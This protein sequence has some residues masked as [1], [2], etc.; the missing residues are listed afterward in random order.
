MANSA[1]LVV[2]VKG[3]LIVLVGRGLSVSLVHL[4]TSGAATKELPPRCTLCM[5]WTWD[6]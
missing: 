4:E 3:N 1:T 5:D 2:V 6:I